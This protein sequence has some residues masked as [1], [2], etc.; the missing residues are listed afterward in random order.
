MFSLDV[1]A[2]L[3]ARL[4]RDRVAI[5]P[6]WSDRRYFFILHG[7]K[8]SS[9]DTIYLDSINTKLY[10]SLNQSEV[11]VLANILSSG[12]L[13]GDLHNTLLF[14]LEDDDPSIVLAAL[15]ILDVAG[16]LDGVTVTIT[17]AYIKDLKLDS[18]IHLVIQNSIVT[19][20]TCD[21]CSISATASVITKSRIHKFNTLNNSIIDFG[22][23]F[24]FTEINMKAWMQTHIVNV[25]GKGQGIESLIKATSYNSLILITHE[26]Q[27]SNI[28]FDDVVQKLLNQ[29]SQN[30]VLYGEFK[31]LDKSS[32][33]GPANEFSFFTEAGYWFYL[34]TYNTPNNSSTISCK[35]ILIGGEL[36]KCLSILTLRNSFINFDFDKHSSEN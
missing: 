4:T 32:G 3:R 17:D 35:E 28:N 30:S 25:Y 27:V 10:P 31:Q 13:S 12:R 6:K 18:D 20:L 2:N 34:D 14:L 36:F 7:D 15:E 33:S 21:K 11:L 1:V 29:G 9:S 19:S 5:Y 23:Y 24:T 8:V 22:D 16:K 26:E